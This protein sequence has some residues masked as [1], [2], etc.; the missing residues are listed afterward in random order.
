V[1]WIETD[2]AS[3]RVEH[4]FDLIV[5]TGHVFQVFLSNHEVEAALKACR[6]QLD[7]NGRIA[8]ETRNPD[9]E[10]WKSWTPELTR[11]RLMVEG[12]GAVDVHYEVYSSEDQLVS[13]KTHFDFGGGDRVVTSNTLR[14]MPVHELSAM[15]QH[16]GLGVC[17]WY[18]DFDGSPRR[19]DSP[20]I[21]A[22][23]RKC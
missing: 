2:A 20:E 15:L 12:L 4:S 8:F 23:A 6:R 17:T 21:I 18:G 1:R 22:V 13:F 7:P 9:V 11:E 10:E 19:E 5:M 16:C 14:F 3:L